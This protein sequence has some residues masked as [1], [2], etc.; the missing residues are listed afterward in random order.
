MEGTQRDGRVFI[1]YPTIRVDV[2]VG[3]DLDRSVWTVLNIA[4]R[5]RRLGIELSGTGLSA[6]NLLDSMEQYWENEIFR[7][8][9][10]L[11]DGNSWT[12]TAV[13][14]T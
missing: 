7:L 9:N 2:R 11:A 13:V 3:F 5:A 12:H 6:D 4:Q 1:R 14:A 10:N 8:L